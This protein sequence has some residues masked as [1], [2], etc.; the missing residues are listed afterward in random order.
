ML[1]NAIVAFSQG[2]AYFH[3]G[4]EILRSK[5]LDRNSYDSGDWFNRIDW[6]LQDNFFGS[7]L[8]P[9]NDNREHWPLMQPLLADASIKPTAADIRFARDA[10]LDLLRIRA[11]SSLFRLRTADEVA[12]RL[13]FP[14]TGPAQV[15]TV[16]AGHLD[17]S[18]LA[19]AGFKELLYLVNV[20]KVAHTL[21]ID[22]LK[23]RPFTLHPVHAA[24]TA[25]DARAGAARFAAEQGA[26][27]VPA[28]TAVVFVVN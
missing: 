24:P 9:A 25:G 17:G 18:G 27:T 10:F 20:D 19:G 11:S 26:F 22:A 2:I 12:R 21:T 23:G 4:Q 7:G 1:G 8:P 16:V 28:R 13:K 5:S 14:N 6:S 3:A 15:P